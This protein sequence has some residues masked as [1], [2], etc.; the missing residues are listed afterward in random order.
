M[1][2]GLTGTP[3]TGKTSVSNL[4]KEEY[5]YKII[6]LNELI[7][8]E[9]L[10]SEVDTKR[11]SVIA[12]M[13]QVIARVNDLIRNDLIR[14]PDNNRGK[15]DEITILESHLSHHIADIVIV[16]R[17]SPDELRKRLSKRKYPPA[18]VQE[19]VEAEALD[20]ILVESFEWCDQ[21]FEI[22]TTGRFVNDIAKDIAEIVGVLSSSRHDKKDILLKFKPG[23]FDW[24]NEID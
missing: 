13:E 12:D 9:H 7:K 22:N 11:D 19:N 10:Y 21:V 15:N 20:V 5:G 24:S 2:I 6:H 17:A 18:K 14:E 4:L 8:E 23:S 3:G 1:L 16:L